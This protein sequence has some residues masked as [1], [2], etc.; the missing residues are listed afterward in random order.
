MS[1]EKGLRLWIKPQPFLYAEIF[2]AS[3]PSPLYGDSRNHIVISIFPH[4]KLDGDSI[5]DE[6]Y[7]LASIH[8]L[9]AYFVIYL[10][11]KL[12]RYFVCF[13]Y[14]AETTNRY[15][16]PRCVFSSMNRQLAPDSSSR[17]FFFKLSTCPMTSSIPC[18]MFG[19]GHI[20]L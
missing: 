20:T 1:N 6:T 11:T 7:F 10:S 4:F 9:N 19:W 5:K 18:S 2:A 12:D 16:G 3:P 17:S 8:L 15:P 13:I 14:L